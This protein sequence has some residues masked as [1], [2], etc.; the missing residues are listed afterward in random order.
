MTSSGEPKLCG[1]GLL[2][3]R[4]FKIDREP[5]PVI[6][7]MM[8]LS[9]KHGLLCVLLAAVLLPST[10]LAED[11]TA[12]KQSLIRQNCSASQFV[13]DQLQKRDAVSRI[14]RGRS[15]DQLTKQIAALN[16]RFAVNKVSVPDIA[17]VSGDI[18]ASIERF[19][20]DYD[21]YYDEISNAL[22]LD[23]KT[24]PV[25]FYQLIQHA[26]DDR[27]SIGN[28]V[29]KIDELLGK[30]RA[31]LLHYQESLPTNISRADQ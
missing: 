14:N 20:A 11:I 25:D 10:V 7:G 30:Y 9:K 29:V 26:R 3:A 22:K 28:E 12:E 27:T 19:R 4:P 15:Y 1:A 24:Q 17:Q 18:Q 21:H 16:N 13:L 2:R 23:C 8:L 5:P 6:I 31:A